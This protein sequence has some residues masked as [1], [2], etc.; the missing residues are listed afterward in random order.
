VLLVLM[1]TSPLLKAQQ[2][3]PPISLGMLIDASTNMGLLMEPA[4]DGMNLFL[5]TLK[6]S[7]EVFVMSFGRN[8]VQLQDFTSDFDAVS[9]SL[10]RVYPRGATSLHE[11][12]VEALD[13]LE[14]G[15]HEMKVIL[16][17][18]TGQISQSDLGR[19]RD[20]IK[21]SSALVYGVGMPVTPRTRL[22]RNSSVQQ[23]TGEA[24]KLSNWIR[25]CETVL[26]AFADESGGAYA[27][28]P[29]Y[30]LPRSYSVEPAFQAIA[31]HL[32]NRN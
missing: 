13:K 6:P 19:S 7:D 9:E 23:A 21:A 3:R 18:T 14:Q 27:V 29:Q 20:A 12:L 24:V 30:G 31:D 1:T 10:D 4:R 5:E 22:G 26:K 17:V 8:V 32:A 16:L 2:S 11:T 25:I 15:Q 28:V